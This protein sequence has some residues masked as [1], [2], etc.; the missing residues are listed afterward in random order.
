MVTRNARQWSSSGSPGSKRLESG[1]RRVRHIAPNPGPADDSCLSWTRATAAEACPNRAGQVKADSNSGIRQDPD[2]VAVPRGHVSR[3]RKA[4]IEAGRPGVTVV[5]Y[6]W[7]GGFHELEKRG[8][9][10]QKVVQRECG[11]IAKHDP[12]DHRPDPT[13]LS[14]TPRGA[15]HLF[16]C[17]ITWPNS[18][19][20]RPRRYAEWLADPTMQR[21]LVAVVARSTPAESTNS[22]LDPS[23]HPSTRGNLPM[24]IRRRVASR[25]SFAIRSLEA[26]GQASGP[27]SVMES[28]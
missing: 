13:C 28:T 19:C 21:H 16:P 9:V 11:Q 27:T 20:S 5:I 24:K 17:D 23:G 14:T 18:Y 15:R 4:A 2:R 8:R 22:L 26:R 12:R 7:I 3:R 25:L 10:A 1:V 6:A